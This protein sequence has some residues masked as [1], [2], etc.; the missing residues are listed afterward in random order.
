MHAIIALAALTLA[1]PAAPPAK[2]NADLWT[3][4]EN[5][6]G[7]YDA[8]PT[9]NACSAIIRSGQESPQNLAAAF[10]NR[11]RAEALRGDHARAIQDYDSAIGLNP[12]FT[13]AFNNRGASHLALADYQH[14]LEDLDQALRLAPDNNDA[15][16]NRGAVLFALRRFE[17]AIQDYSRAIELSPNMADLYLR[18]SECALSLGK[19]TQAA[20][21]LDQA[22]RLNNSSASALRLRGY[23]NF[24]QRKIKSSIADY[25]EAIRLEPQHAQ[26]LIDRANSY[27]VI[28]RY[29]QA[30]RDYDKALILTP[31]AEPALRNRCL[32]RAAWGRELDLA[33]NDCEAAFAIAPS[34]MTLSQRA[35]VHMRRGDLAEALQDFDLSYSKDPRLTG[36]LYGRGVARLRLGQNEEGMADIAAAKRADPS[37]DEAYARYGIK[38]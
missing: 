28:E 12:G 9:I 31:N 23:V 10:S 24:L 6:A 38:P 18:R 30:I 3:Q 5:A 26:T 22:V 16:A 35:M 32:A 4:C 36:S 13:A 17:S 1:T 7:V 25:N 29:D 8:E 2:Q 33:L 34:P 19:L 20:A 27:L 21:D 15:L 37:V 11:G 14:A